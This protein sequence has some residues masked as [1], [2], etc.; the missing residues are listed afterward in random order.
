[1]NRLSHPWIV[2]LFNAYRTNIPS[3]DHKSCRS[4]RYA[5]D[6]GV[7]IKLSVVATAVRQPLGV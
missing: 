7:T 1:M 2:I 3:C 4:L 5:L 6:R